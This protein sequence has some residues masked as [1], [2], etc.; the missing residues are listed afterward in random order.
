MRRTSVLLIVLSIA[1]IGQV[2]SQAK[3]VADT[4]TLYFGTVV[5][6]DSKSLFLSITNT[7]NAP[8]TYT[9]KTGP[10]SVD[11]KLANAGGNPVLDPDSS[12]GF[13]VTF[14]PQSITATHIH[15]DSIHFKFTGIPDVVVQL[16]GL[17]HVPVLDSVSIDD[18]FL[19]YAGQLITIA[20][21]FN[22]PL[23][24]ALDSIR[25]FSEFLTYDPQIMTL[26]SISPGP[27]LQGWNVPSPPLELVLGHPQIFGT[28]TYRAMTGPGPF[29][30]LVFRL[31]PYAQVFQSSSIVQDNFLFGTGFEPLMSGLPGKVTVIDSC[32]PVATTLVTPGTMIEPNMPNPFQSETVFTY[33]VGP[34]ATGEAVHVRLQLYD[35]RGQLV[36]CPVDEDAVAGTHSVMMPRGGLAAGVYSCVYEAG[37]YRS[38]RKVVVLP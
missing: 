37:V 30:F 22:G 9:G 12:L 34:S 7:G 5:L 23:T 2:Y 18:T 29:L 28:A 13:S 31:V 21:R 8:V 14:S 10:F 1:G 24:G 11:Y 15:L 36:A 32:T 16:I 3:P 20:Q 33:Q 26:Q 19:G 25:R 38:V 17:D 4:S 35:A 6:R 27:C